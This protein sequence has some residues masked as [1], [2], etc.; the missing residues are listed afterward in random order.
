MLMCYGQ[1]PL[2]LITAIP[3][4]VDTFLRY[5]HHFISI[6]FTFWQAIYGK[7]VLVLFSGI[8]S[9]IRFYAFYD[10]GGPISH[11]SKNLRKRFLGPCRPL[12]FRPPTYFMKFGV[13][14]I[15]SFGEI[16]MS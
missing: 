1:S 15:I 6:V 11:Q 3:S 12:P 4:N 8:N 13:P 9:I 10:S 16:L 7:E 2:P 14:T 5:F